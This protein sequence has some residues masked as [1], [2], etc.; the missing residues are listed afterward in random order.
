M[1]IDYSE[2][3]C[4]FRF[5]PEDSAFDVPICCGW[6]LLILEVDY[7]AGHEF[8]KFF[9]EKYR[10]DILGPHMIN[11]ETVRLELNMFL[12]CLFDVRINKHQD[13]NK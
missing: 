10:D 9:H 12:S 3:L 6:K 7:E 13:I 8:N 5:V 1:R 4:G 2:E 11:V